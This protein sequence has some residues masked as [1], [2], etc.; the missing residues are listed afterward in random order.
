VFEVTCS[1]DEP[2]FEVVVD[3]VVETG[4]DNPNFEQHSWWA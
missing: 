1:T 3:I 4:A 2:I